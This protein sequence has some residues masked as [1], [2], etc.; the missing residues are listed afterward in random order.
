MNEVTRSLDC[1]FC[2]RNAVPSWGLSTGTVSSAPVV[3]GSRL[4]SKSIRAGWTRRKCCQPWDCRPEK[5]D[6]VTLPGWRGACR[7]VRASCLLPFTQSVWCLDRQRSG[8]CDWTLC[9]SRILHMEVR[10]F[11]SQ[12]YTL[13]DIKIFYNPDTF[14]FIY[15]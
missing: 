5:R 1:S 4:P 3:G 8:G 11:G 7:S 10:T 12:N 15:F 2:A 14:C 6:L 13:F 9:L